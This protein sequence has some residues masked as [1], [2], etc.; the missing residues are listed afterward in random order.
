M[1]WIGR[2]AVRKAGERR[3]FLAI[4]GLVRAGKTADL[5]HGTVPPAGVRS[6]HVGAVVIITV[7][8]NEA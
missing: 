6:Q 5:H 8:L 4:S 3:E 7:K 2:P 1:N